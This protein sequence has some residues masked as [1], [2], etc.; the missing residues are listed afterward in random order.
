MK[1]VELDKLAANGS[2]ID[3]IVAVIGEFT[4]DMHRSK[5]EAYEAAKYLSAHMPAG[6]EPLF[7][8]DD[9]VYPLIPDKDDSLKNQFKTIR[10]ALRENFSE[11]KVRFAC[12]L[13]DMMRSGASGTNRTTTSASGVSVG[14]SVAVGASSSTSSDASSSINDLYGKADGEQKI[15]VLDMKVA[16]IGELSDDRHRGVPMALKMAD[17]A[18]VQLKKSGLALY[19]SDDGEYDVDTVS[20]GSGSESEFKRL[21]AALRENFS[22]EKL[23]RA[24]WLIRDLRDQG[25]PKYE[26]RSESGPKA[27]TRSTSC[28]RSS[29]TSA[30]TSS[31]RSDARNFNQSTF[32]NHS[33]ASTQG[34]GKKM[35]VLIWT[36]VVVAIG[37]IVA[38]I[39]KFFK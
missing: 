7:E 17:E 39:V 25:N 14:V 36:A 28:G 32:T 11:E 15:S 35:A 6:L 19:E 21:Q 13:I 8:P 22:R 9:G 37:V 5:C 16:I 23:Q 24:I 38:A 33:Q 31:S 27:S 3:M 18:E 34:K 29:T 2:R 10:T 26:A 12:Q 20:P 30:G 4:D 1:Q